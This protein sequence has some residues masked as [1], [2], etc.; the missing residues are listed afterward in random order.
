MTDQVCLTSPTT[1][2]ATALR[3]EITDPRDLGE[4]PD[5]PEAPVEPAVDDDQILAPAPP[6]EAGGIEIPRGPNILPPPEAPELPEELTATVTI[7]VGDDVSTGDLA[8]DGVEV[9]SFR[10]NVPEIAKYTFRR[11][12][13]EYS[14]K[15]EEMAP[16]YI[17]GGH[18]YGQGSSREHAALAP[19]Q[20]GIRAII[21][22]S[23]A[24]IHRRNLISQGILPLL[25][26][27]ESDY[28]LFEQGQSWTLPDLRTR[29][30]DGERELPIR[31]DSG[32]ETTLLAEL[33]PRERD[34]LL[35]GGVLRQ[36]RKEGSA[37]GDTGAGGYPNPEVPR[38]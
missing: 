13:P 24:R 29:L 25:F 15:A 2:A 33:S 1:A 4:Y 30:S 14:R 19:L 35:A 27:D 22:K 12:D 9:M 28:E 17:V 32:G 5:L 21:A 18:N 7:V 36:L 10:S 34:I 26:A 31:S 37:M 38:G 11:F 8:P 6:E 3:G 23:F 16:G 20:L